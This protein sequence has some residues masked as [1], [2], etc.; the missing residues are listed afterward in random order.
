[1]T[2][3]TAATTQVVLALVPL[4]TLILA[5][6]QGI[7]RFRWQGL[8]GALVAAAG[9]YL[10]FRES[11]GAASVAALLALVG[12]AIG[13]AEVNIVV[14]KFPPVHPMVQAGI[15]M[16][17]GGLMQLALSLIVGEPWVVPREPATLLSLVYLILIGSI[18]L[19]VL[20]LVVLGR[21]TATGAS[22]S[23]L[24]APLVTVVLGVELLGEPVTP[25]FA[26]G[27]VLVLAGV[28]LGAFTN[29]A[30]PGA[31]GSR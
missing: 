9:V 22:Y 11:V 7:E 16:A 15:G 17:V 19:F 14:K 12:G 21:W 8:A 26:V 20:Y 23:W 1:M 5:A 27:G 25:W 3:V 13:L 29:A 24:I 31:R 6:V 18:G 30:G 28:Y 4:L 2:E 10:L